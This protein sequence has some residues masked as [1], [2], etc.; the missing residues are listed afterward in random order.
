MAFG[1]YLIKCGNTEIPSNFINEKTFVATPNM[2]FEK[3]AQRDANVLLHRVTSPNVK[4]VISF[5]T[6]PM[7]ESEK[8]QLLTIFKNAYT[9]DIQRKLPITYWN[10][11]DG[12]YKTI[13][14]YIADIEYTIRQ[15]TSNDVYYEPFTVN[16]IEY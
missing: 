16:F 6:T 14:C 8:S 3:K 1:G 10:I 4:Q 7:N 5:Q 11:E 15:I 9:I 12:A 13:T 2:R